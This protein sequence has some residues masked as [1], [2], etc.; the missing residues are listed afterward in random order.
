MPQ[1][2]TSAPPGAIPVNRHP[3][4]VLSPAVAVAGMLVG[5]GGAPVELEMAEGTR[6]EV[7]T[8]GAIESGMPNFARHDGTLLLSHLERRSHERWAL[9][10]TEVAAD[11]SV[12]SG[13]DVVERDDFFVNWA[14]FPSV[15]P[16]GS[17][18]AAWAAHW[19]QRGPHGGYDYGVRLSVSDDGGA[20]W[21]ESWTPHEDET[22][23]EHGFVSILP[24][25]E[26]FELIWLD[27]RQF[28][29]GRERMQLRAGRGGLSGAIGVERVVDE[30]VC[31]CCQT[32]VAPT[33][34][35]AVA[36][37]RNRTGDEIRDVHAARWDRTTGS[38]TLLGPVHEDGWR[39]AACP[40]NGPAVATDGTRTAV[41]WF[42]AA[43]DVPAVHLAVAGPEAEQFSPPVRIDRGA[44]VGRVDVQFDAAGDPW[45]LWMES[46]ADGGAE[47]LL[48]RVEA[49]R[50]VDRLL[51]IAELGAARGTG[52]PRFVFLEGGSALVAWTDLDGD[53][54]RLRLLKL[55][56]G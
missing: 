26:A 2:S 37:Y 16:F 4:R 23:T 25:D 41:A 39:I 40:V 8:G 11:G 28:A 10:V 20:T 15:T 45:V 9:R 53:E 14:D 43:G 24:T 22:S 21:G 47:L 54:R 32:D 44:P 55:P 36:V 48:A 7:V 1:P 12:V 29:E 31:D 38:W 50:A 19:L 3:F 35:G 46:V 5:C 42:T 49:G 6:V 13:G 17:S 56:T 34:A 52:F 33:D 30:L 27:G 51:R 18:G